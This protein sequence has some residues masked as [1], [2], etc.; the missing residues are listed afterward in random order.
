MCSLEWRDEACIISGRH[1]DWQSDSKKTVI[2]LWCR[3]KSGHS[4]LLLVNGFQPYIEIS[5]PMTN[6]DSKSSKLSLD[7]V[8]ND[9]NVSGEP[10]ELGNKLHNGQERPHWRI[11]VKSRDYYSYN[12]LIKKLSNVSQS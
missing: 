7:E 4:I 8:T 11:N 2:E 6:S 9:S 12:T 5:D 1:Q 3:S 10:I